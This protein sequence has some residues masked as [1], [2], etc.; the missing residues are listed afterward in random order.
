M[1]LGTQHCLS[2]RIILPYYAIL[3]TYQLAKGRFTVADW[4]LAVGRFAR[5]LPYR[6]G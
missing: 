5:Q 1:S 6:F 3:G 2:I 4:L